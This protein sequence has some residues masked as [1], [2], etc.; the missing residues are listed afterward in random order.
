[1]TD[2][3]GIGTS[4]CETNITLNPDPVAVQTPSTAQNNESGQINHF[5]VN[6]TLGTSPYTY[7]WLVN[8]TAVTGATSPVFA[9]HPLH[10]ATYIVNVTVMDS[11]GWHV[12]TPGVTETAYSGPFVNLMASASSIDYHDSVTYTGSENGGVLPITFTWYLNS[13]VVQTG[14]F[15]DWNFTP[16]GAAAYSVTF[17]AIDADDAQFNSTQALTVYAD[18]VVGTPSASPVSVDL[19]QSTIISANALFGSGG[20]S[21]V[22][23]GLPTGCTGSSASFACTPETSGIFTVSVVVTDSNGHGASSGTLSI[24]VYPDPSVTVPSASRPS[25]DMGQFLWFNTTLTAPGSGGDT[26][27]WKGLPT[28]CTNSS[29]ASLGP[30]SASASNTYTVLVKVRDSNGFVSS[31]TGITF[32]V[33]TDPFAGVPEASPAAI[34]Q[35]QWTNF[36]TAVGGGKGSLTVSWSDLPTGCFTSN[37]TTLACRPTGNGTYSVEVSVEDGNQAQVE[38]GI[39]SFT[40]YATLREGAPTINSNAIDYDQTTTIYT[41][42]SG[43]FGPFTYVWSGLPGGCTSD[44][45]AFSCTPGV[46]GS[47]SVTVKVTDSNSAVVTSP[48]SMLTVNLDPIIAQH[49]YAAQTNETGQVSHYTVTVTHGTAPFTYQWMV[50]GT[51][52]AGA[53]SSVFAFHLLHSGNYTVNVSVT[54]SAGWRVWTTAVA[55][56]VSQGPHVSIAPSRTV[57][58]RGQTLTFVGSEGGGFLPLSFAWYLNG[59][60]VQS[61]PSLYWNFTPTGAATYT[62]SLWVTDSRLVTVNSTP[63]SIIVYPR[64]AVSTPAASPTSVDLGQGVTL[65]TV[66][67]FGS[68]GYVYQW[69]GLPAGCSGSLASLL[70]TP[71]SV[72]M[73]N[74]TVNATDSNGAS[75]RSS[76]LSFRVYADPTINSL[77]ANRS[78]AEV[79]QLVSFNTTSSGGSGG[80]TYTW[81]G[82]PTGCASANAIAINC[83]PTASGSFLI[84]VTVRDS[85]GYSGKS[86]EVSFVVDPTVTVTTPAATPS[87]I[88]LAQSVVFRVNASLGAGGFIYSWIGL[89]KGCSSS[90]LA[91]ID[92]TPTAVGS[93]NVSVKVTDADKCSA[94]S[95]ALFFAVHTRPAVVVHSDINETFVSVGVSLTVSISGGS[96]NH[97]VRW[98]LNGSNT[99]F[100]GD[101]LNVTFSHPG[102][103]TYVAWVTDANGAVASSAPIRVQVLPLPPKGGSGPQSTGRWLMVLALLVIVGVLITIVLLF[104]RRSR[105]ERKSSKPAAPATTALP[106]TQS[107]YIAPR[108]PQGYLD[109]LAAVPEGWHEGKVEAAYGTYHVTESDRTRFVEE[110]KIPQEGQASSVGGQ[111]S[112]S[113]IELDASRPWSLKI[114][115]EGIIM[116]EIPSSGAAKE[117]EEDEEATKGAGEPKG[118]ERPVSASTKEYA[119]RILKSLA[120]EP[121]SLDGIKEEVPIDE[122]ELLGLLFALTK[123]KFIAPC[124]TKS[125]SAAFVLTPL[126]RKMGH[127]FLQGESRTR[128]VGMKPK[129]KPKEVSPSIAAEEKPEKESTGRVEIPCPS[130]RTLVEEG[131][132]ICRVCGAPLAETWS[133]VKKKDKS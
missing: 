77:T 37:T 62:V 117:W 119:Y 26:Y 17:Q 84:N 42:T 28:G 33:Y 81:A 75:A 60:D 82:L 86:S 6:V 65:T 122:A 24:T 127:Q 57:M 74:I 126:G 40:V 47:F 88:D 52:E 44:T 20:F 39:L 15:R 61:G 16:L 67:S 53:T 55:E 100:T 51:A 124:M 22:W 76:S 79:G 105:Q 64:P 8:D 7:Q 110:F 98:A 66:A 90:N 32:T 10:P 3:N 112:S 94:T 104:V 4:L 125:G 36:T 85:N 35:G 43:G 108:T 58:D 14:P 114:T 45:A 54:D 106:A 121:N 96:G 25:S 59:S 80:N 2:S 91:S 103:Y 23:S 38:S 9:F 101:R 83:K 70:C 102:N 49:P 116:E 46:S 113:K 48:A 72:G 73:F 27:W 50:N 128:S 93:Y 30:C 97:T 69:S 107:M 123:A 41:T 89:P 18:P 120:T 87:S 99:S 131:T 109:S 19:S 29:T 31:S 11:T 5:A 129:H 130:C 1:V 132:R 92:C 133:S 68:G 95:M 13:S 34:D 71:S 111:P 56:N 78:S 12:S 115:P 118:D 21:Y 63:M